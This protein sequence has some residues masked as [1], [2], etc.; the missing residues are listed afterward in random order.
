MRILFSAVL[1]SATTAGAP[2]LAWNDNM[3]QPAGT[4][5]A[6]WAYPSAAN[7]CPSGLQPVVVGGVI[8]CGQPNRTGNQ[9]APAPRRTYAAS[10]AYVAY[11][12]GYGESEEMSE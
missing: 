6:I 7:Y 5:I 12:K 4:E 1:A 9:S 10:P 3:T 2:V 11:G 8:C